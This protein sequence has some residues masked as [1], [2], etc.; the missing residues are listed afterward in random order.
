MIV[1]GGN[2]DPA[3]YGE[4][5]TSRLAGLTMFAAGNVPC[6]VVRTPLVHVDGVL[7]ASSW[8]MVT[9]LTVV[10]ELPE[11]TTGQRT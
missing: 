7:T 5:I 2:I 9:P 8:P 1:S 3:R 11:A 6:R 4:L 10:V